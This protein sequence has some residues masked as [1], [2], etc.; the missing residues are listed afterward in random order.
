MRSGSGSADLPIGTIRAQRN[1]PDD[2]QAEIERLVVIVEQAVYRTKLALG[3]RCS[4][5]GLSPGQTPPIDFRNLTTH[6]CRS[7]PR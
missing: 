4:A 1:L 5:P 2:E 7:V 3:G 6:F